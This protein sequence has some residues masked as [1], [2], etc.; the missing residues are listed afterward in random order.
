MIPSIPAGY[1]AKVVAVANNPDELN[2]FEPLEQTA[3]EFTRVMVQFT[4]DPS[5]DISKVAQSIESACASNGI[6]NWPEY[7]NTHTFIEGNVLYFTYVKSS[8]WIGIVLVIIGVL[9][10]IAP[11]IMWFVSPAFREMINAVIMLSIMFLLMWF[12]KKMIPAPTAPK[13]IETKEKRPPLAERISARLSSLGES[14]FRIE[15]LYRTAP[16]TAASETTSAASSLISIAGAIR[17]APETVMSGHRKAEAAK[18]VEGLSREL[19]EYTEGLTPEQKEKL[20]REQEIVRE[21]T[22][23]YP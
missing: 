14:I 7:P 16:A 8:P 19:A 13:E 4:L 5:E 10:L 2:N 1:T 18:K 17:G 21:L 6:P 3:P 11:I 12:M 20:E 9:T 15:S 22:E 23:M